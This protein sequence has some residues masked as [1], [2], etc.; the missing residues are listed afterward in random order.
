[1]MPPMMYPMMPKMPM[2]PPMMQQMPMMQQPMQ[3]RSIFK[4][5]QKKQAEVLMYNFS[6]TMPMML[7]GASS[8]STDDA[9]AANT[10][11]DA[12]NTTNDARR[13]NTCTRTIFSWRHQR[14][15]F[16][17]IPPYLSHL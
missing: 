9:D 4:R 17:Q 5:R 10:T 11:N 1:M 8:D 13:P 3:S 14:R 16:P 6:T 15:S 2:M 12:A 7:N